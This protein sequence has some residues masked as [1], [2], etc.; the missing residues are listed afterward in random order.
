MKRK[1]S[2]AG[3]ENYSPV[4]LKRSPMQ[5]AIQDEISR[6]IQN[7]RNTQKYKKSALRALNILMYATFSNSY[8]PSWSSDDGSAPVVS[9]FSKLSEEDIRAEIGEYYLDYVDVKWIDI[10]ESDYSD[11]ASTLSTQPETS[12]QNSIDS[13]S[14]A[15][16][17]ISDDKVFA[18]LETIDLD[19]A[20][21][22]LDANRSTVLTNQSND[23]D[24]VSPSSSISTIYDEVRPNSKPEDLWLNGPAVP[25]ID[26]SK[27]WRQGVV[28]DTELVIYHSLP[29]IPTRQC[30]ISITT[31][32]SKLSKIDL[33]KL[34][35]DC[36]FYTRPMILYSENCGLK[37]NENFGGVIPIKGFTQ[38]QIIDNIIK[39]PVVT[40]MTREGKKHGHSIF[41]EFEKF[42]EIDGELY[43]T[44]DMIDKI[45]D[46][47]KLKPSWSIIAEYVVRRYLLERDILHI[48][49]KYKM[50]GT[51][52]PYLTLFMPAQDYVAAG[53]K[54]VVVIAKQCVESRISYLQSRSPI[55]RR[56]NENA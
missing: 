56:L 51:L 26:T 10:P 41:I 43:K 6:I 17:N 25:Q 24:N 55:I 2:E 20:L 54:D 34:Y 14:K 29:E 47:K 35:P 12:T 19:E 42:I 5:M 9:Y 32:A 49:H 44:T 15:D 16:N 39:Y 31:D 28:D 4:Q 38:K 22:A 33:M 21:S 27:I 30:E 46:L 48:D 1:F 8:P 23:S 36:M 13:S 37:M 50:Y 53:H 40:G 52:N 18:S 11:N 45:P 3:L 7:F